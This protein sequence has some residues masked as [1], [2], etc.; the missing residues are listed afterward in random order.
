M[1]NNPNFRTLKK[2]NEKELSKDGRT[3]EF[4]QINLIQ[5]NIIY[6]LKGYSR[7]SKLNLVR[8]LKKCCKDFAYKEI[9]TKHKHNFKI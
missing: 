2:K 6:D 8:L 3:Q 7:N 5:P 9:N 4:R 1:K